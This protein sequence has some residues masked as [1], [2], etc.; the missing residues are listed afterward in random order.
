MKKK[1]TLERVTLANFE[2]VL[3]LRTKRSQKD[4]CP[5]N[6]YSLVQASFYGQT[7]WRRMI[8]ADG[9]PVGFV[10]V[11]TGDLKKDGSLFLWRFLID[12]RQQKHGYG[13]QAFD[14]VLSRIRKA[15]P[16]ATTLKSCF[17][18]GEGGPEGF[19]LSRGFRITD[20]AEAPVGH[21]VYME[22]DLTQPIA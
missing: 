19:W 22:L 16:K 4:F 7:A 21:E 18:R 2:Q 3:G 9:V 11:Y 12:G 14:L 5:D 8:R 20:N 1:L 6:A 15:W 17:V 10:M 13:R